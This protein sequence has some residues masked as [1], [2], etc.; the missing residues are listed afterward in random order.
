VSPASRSIKQSSLF[1]ITLLENVNNTLNINRFLSEGFC[2]S[3]DAFNPRRGCSD[4]FAQICLFSLRSEWQSVARPDEERRGEKESRA[5]RL[6][7]AA[8]AGPARPGP[9]RPATGSTRITSRSSHGE[10][11]LV[12]TQET[13][14]LLH[15]KISSTRQG[16]L[17]RGKRW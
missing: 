10:S 11:L 6:G 1:N 5:Q 14:N 17:P 12:P 2:S 9:T 8:G 16:R 15:K 4:Y 3:P 7:G 13:N